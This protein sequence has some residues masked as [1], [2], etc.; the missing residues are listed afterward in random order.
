M[1]NYVLSICIIILLAITLFFFGYKYCIIGALFILTI[2]IF[3]ANTKQIISGGDDIDIILPLPVRIRNLIS[4]KWKEQFEQFKNDSLKNSLVHFFEQNNIELIVKEFTSA[5]IN[6]KIKIFAGAI[7]VVVLQSFLANNKR[8]KGRSYLENIYNVAQKNNVVSFYSS[9]PRLMAL[10]FLQDKFL[11]RYLEKEDMLSD[12]LDLG[13]YFVNIN[14]IKHKI[15]LCTN[16]INKWMKLD[17]DFFFI[18]MHSKIHAMAVLLDKKKQVINVIDSDHDWYKEMPAKIKKLRTESIM[19]WLP[20]HCRDWSIKHNFLSGSILSFQS[21]TWDNYCQ[22]WNGLISILIIKNPTKKINDIVKELYIVMPGKDNT[23]KMINTIQQFAFYIY[24]R[25]KLKYFYPTIIR[26][27]VDPRSKILIDDYI[28]K[29]KDTILD[30]ASFTNIYKMILPNSLMLNYPKSIQDL[31]RKIQKDK[32]RLRVMKNDF[33]RAIQNKKI[34]K[35]LNVDTENYSKIVMMIKDKIKKQ[36]GVIINLSGKLSKLLDE[37]Y[38]KMEHKRKE[39]IKLFN[40][41]YI[42]NGFRNR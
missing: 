11:K 32:I 6:K 12:K 23:E 28:N 39:K 37:N 15:V 22:T 3:G 19:L 24:K 8:F 42:N 10:Y 34:D 13:Q 7:N 35:E 26:E 4:T 1:N 2:L 5:H 30:K 16:E 27:F 33:E 21:T 25:Y 29:K 18:M 38:N 14:K 9:D 20:K 17:K 41:R 31:F 36:K 40:K